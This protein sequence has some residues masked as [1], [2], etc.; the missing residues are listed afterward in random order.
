VTTVP[1]P[2]TDVDHFH[3]WRP[4]PY[5][6][7]YSIFRYS[8]DRTC[9]ASPPF[10]TSNPSSVP[11]VHPSRRRPVTVRIGQEQPG[12]GLVLLSHF[13]QDAHSQRVGLSRDVATV[14]GF[15]HQFICI[16][17]GDQNPGP[18]LVPARTTRLICIVNGI[19]RTRIV[20]PPPLRR[21]SPY[22]PLFSID[23]AACKAQRLGTTK[24]N[25]SGIPTG[26]AT[27]RAA[28]IFETSR[29]VQSITL[30]PTTIVPAFNTRRRDQF[31]SRP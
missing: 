2:A 15:G 3:M 16:R 27:S 20:D 29:T 8:I 4:I 19:P 24:V 11:A 13:E 14:F 9:R 26:L 1:A 31:F 25:L 17:H 21:T 5:A 7:V 6:T 22:A 12:F 18:P 23:D 28:P 30:L 10:R